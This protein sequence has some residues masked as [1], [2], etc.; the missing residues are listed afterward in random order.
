MRLIFPLA[1][2]LVAVFSVTTDRLPISYDS[3]LCAHGLCRFDQ[4]TASIDQQG[5]NTKNILTVLAQDPANPLLW[6]TYGEL[7][8]VQGK[9]EEAA[10]MYDHAIELGPHMAPVL[11]RTANFDFTHDRMDH[12]RLMAKQILVRTEAFDQILFSYFTSFRLPISQVLDVAVPAE[13]RPARSWL[14][15]LRSNGAGRDIQETWNWMMQHGLIDERTAV[16]LTRTLWD[17]RSYGAAQQAWVDWLGDNAGGYLHPERIWNP[18]FEH[19]PAGSPFDW[20][21]TAPTS[22]TVERADGLTVRFS[23]TE[24]VSFS[25]I[26]NFVTVRPGPYRFTAEI[27]ATGLTT[28]QHPLFR[29]FDPVRPAALDLETAPI[30]DTR[31]RT[32]LRLDFTVPPGTVAIQIQLDRHPSE[33]FDNKIAGT[34]HLYG[35][36]LRPL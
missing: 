25:H 19:E 4:M 9:T 8:A 6:S 34:L 23:G 35:V 17:R 20:T 24:N 12:A 1:S 27:E 5:L 32:T 3:S 11:M 16:D 26:R 21:I 29:L 13:E 22:V 10:A 15:W 7:L 36:S 18:R 14:S 33:R 2:L 30:D 31:G 28:D